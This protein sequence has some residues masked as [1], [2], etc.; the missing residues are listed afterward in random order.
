MRPFNPPR[1]AFGPFGPK[2]GNRVENEFPG[3]SGPGVQKVK[4]R[5]EKESK[6]EKELK[7]P[8]FDSFSTLIL[9]F[10]GPGAG[11]PK[12]PKAPLGGLKGCKA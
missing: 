11:R 4:I 5:V 6:L 2:V 12:G 10:W 8:L 3:P 9:T 7:F 1:G